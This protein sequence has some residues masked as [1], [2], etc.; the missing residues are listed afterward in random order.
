MSNLRNVSDKGPDR[1]ASVGSTTIVAIATPAGTGG[2]AVIRVSG[3]DALEICQRGWKG[4]DLRECSSHTAHFGKLIDGE[5]NVIDECVAVIFRGPNSFTGE[6]T[7]ELSVHGSPWIQAKAVETLISYGAAPAEAGE[8]TRRAFMNGRIDLAQ[9]EGVADLI[10]ASS[11][12]AHRLAMQQTSGGFSK[13]I[14]SLRERLTEFAAL[15]E[16]ELDFSEEDV[17]FADRKRLLTLAKETREEVDCL[18]ATFRSG[19]ALKSGVP[20]VIAGLPN[21][22]KSTLLNRLLREEKAIVTAVAGTTRDILED[23]IEINGILFR[24]VDTA[25]L[26]TTTDEVE[27]IGIDRALDRLQKARIAIWVSD[28]SL[29]LAPQLEELERHLPT[30]KANDT[31]LIHFINKS[32]LGVNEISGIR[33]DFYKVIA[34][35]ASTGESL[36]DFDKVIVG[37]A[38]TGEAIEELEKTL[39]KFATAEHNPDSELIVTNARHAEALRAAGEALESA[40]EGLKSGLPTDLIAM[41][42]RAAI[43]HLS[44]LTGALTTADLLHH[45]FSRFC[46]GK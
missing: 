5:V 9:A 7:V 12:A 20:V 10:V 45:I 39:G 42:I 31:R 28:G 41:D 22:G 2:I 40:T 35:S 11:R 25:G 26:H 6:N 18:A 38:A 19:Q 14:D 1:V 3:P 8:F 27:L 44:E 33:E 4:V 17:E 15:L 36:K 32:D 29:P 24:F 34:S 21:A 16:L 23:T 30:L 43:A 46:V 13:R 37:S